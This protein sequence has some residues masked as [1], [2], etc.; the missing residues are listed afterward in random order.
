MTTEPT[1]DGQD[2][3]T[4]GPQWE[5]LIRDNFSAPFTM[6]HGD[7]NEAPVPIQVRICYACGALV[8]VLGT[9]VHLWQHVERRDIDPTKREDQHG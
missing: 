1:T 4:D 2:V 5:A 9:G 3:V 6:W 8:L 7:A